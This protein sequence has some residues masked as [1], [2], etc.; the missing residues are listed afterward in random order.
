[1]IGAGLER[2]LP[3][4]AAALYAVIADVESYPDFMPGWESAS[5]EPGG[6]AGEL[7]V[8]Q[9]VHL[10]GRRWDFDSRARLDPP[11]VLRIEAGAPFRH[12][13]LQWELQPLSGSF[14]R[15][16]A[17]LR[18][19]LDDPVLDALARHALPALLRETT[20]ALERRAAA[21]IPLR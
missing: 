1:M 19:E 6:D 13:E 18:A 14:T 4:P 15:L 3:W 20:D 5:V 10:L 7:H 9:G 17:R 12:F 2:V 21:L 16:R 8:R 11:R